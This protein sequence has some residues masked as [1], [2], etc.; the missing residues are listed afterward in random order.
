VISW[1][2]DA[3]LVWVKAAYQ[4]TANQ[5]VALGRATLRTTHRVAHSSGR[6][7]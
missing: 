5:P 4:P 7:G 2:V 3:R 1:S 6:A